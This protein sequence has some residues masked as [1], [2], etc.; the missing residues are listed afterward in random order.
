M[1]TRAEPH[2]RVGHARPVRCCDTADGRYT[3][4][5]LA[6]GVLRIYR[7]RESA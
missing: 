4:R 2:D 1:W 7:R 5:D 3:G 6:A